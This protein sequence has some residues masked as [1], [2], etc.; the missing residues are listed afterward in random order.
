MRVDST[1]EEPVVA[2]RSPDRQRGEVG[3]RVGNVDDKTDLVVGDGRHM[4]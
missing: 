1:V 2:G 4:D 3:S